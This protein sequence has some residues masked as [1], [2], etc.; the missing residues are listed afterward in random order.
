M[1]VFVWNEDNVKNFAHFYGTSQVV[2][3][4]ETKEKAID[5]VLEKKP[6]VYLQIQHY[7]YY[8]IPQVETNKIDEN[9]NHLQFSLE[10]AK[11]FKRL[12]VKEDGYTEKAS[13]PLI[14]ELDKE[15]IFVSE[16]AD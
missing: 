11:L 9:K 14:Y 2:V 16:A 10:Y 1:K 6:W 13:Q 3:I 7:W 12:F 8:E 5:M 15:L 4:A